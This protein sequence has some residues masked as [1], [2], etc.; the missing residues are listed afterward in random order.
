MASPAR[1]SFISASPRR[2]ENVG[3]RH[4]LLRVLDAEA[5]NFLA[6]RHVSQTNTRGAEQA[7][8]LG[9]E[10]ARLG[11]EHLPF[12]RAQEDR[13]R[14]GPCAEEAEHLGVVCLQRGGFGLGDPRRNRSR[15]RWPLDT[16]SSSSRTCARMRM[17][18]VV[19]IVLL[20]DAVANER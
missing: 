11:R 3:R 20:V 6:L 10:S 1:W 13:E 2:L 9:D 5:E 18:N 12:G 17:R 15:P 8:P 19:E 14:S 4:A 16:R 7:E